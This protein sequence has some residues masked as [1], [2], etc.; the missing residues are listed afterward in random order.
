M[1]LEKLVQLGW[2]KVEPSSP[3]EI[4]DLFSIVDRSQAD[5]K[6]EGISDDLRFQAAYNGIL[7]LANIAL[8][9]SGFRVSLGQGHHQRVIESLEH[10]LT[11]DAA[12][13]ERWVRK[14]KSHSQKRNTTSYDL[15]GGVSPTDLAQV[16]RDLALLRD[17][18]NEWLKTT[19]PEL[20]KD[21]SKQS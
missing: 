13:R 7:M 21:D 2:Y 14:I 1:S 11:Q 8:R 19:H 3:R 15:A 5:M 4:A 20:L 10:T 17:Q 9:A 16:I 12:A 6:V 18:V